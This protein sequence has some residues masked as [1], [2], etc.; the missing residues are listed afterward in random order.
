MLATIR[1]F[2]QERLEK[3]ED[4]AE[5]R[6]RHAR[7]YLDLA[8]VADEELTG[9]DHADAFARLAQEQ[10]NIR[11][12]LTCAVGSDPVLALELAAAAGW[13]W[14]VRGQLDEGTRWLEAALAADAGSPATRATV[15]MRAVRSRTRVATTVALRL[16]T[17]WRC[18][19]AEMA[20]ISPAPSVL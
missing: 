8:R 7:H 1:E 16:T 3:S 11:A 20:V 9:P 14:F 15:S 19:C 18:N 12:A 4:A 2:A 13:F 10:D 6:A 5:V 17:V